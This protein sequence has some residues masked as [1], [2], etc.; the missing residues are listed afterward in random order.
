[1]SYEAGCSASSGYEMG[2]SGCD[3]SDGYYNPPS[4]PA[5]C[6]SSAGYYNPSSG[7]SVWTTSSSGN[8]NDGYSGSR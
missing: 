6:S 7:S 2:S 3:A 4:S 1:M 5:V 8:Y